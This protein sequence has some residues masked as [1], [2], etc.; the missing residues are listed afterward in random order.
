MGTELAGFHNDGGIFSGDGHAGFL[1]VTR[2]A[3]NREFSGNFSR[4][5]G[6]GDKSVTVA[7]SAGLVMG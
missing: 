7:S 4:A 5:V 2:H 3:G 1:R 6:S